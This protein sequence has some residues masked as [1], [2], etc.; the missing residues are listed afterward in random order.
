M[1]K[2]FIFGT[3]S[4]CYFLSVINIV[5]AENK[6]LKS[7][8]ATLSDSMIN[9]DKASKVN[10]IPEKELKSIYQVLTN[11]YKIKNTQAL[12]EGINECKQR[13]NKKELGFSNECIA[14]VVFQDVKKLTLIDYSANDNNSAKAMLEVIVEKTT[15][16]MTVHYSNTKELKFTFKPSVDTLK[17]DY[18]V[19][20][21]TY[22]QEVPIMKHFGPWAIYQG[23]NEV[24]VK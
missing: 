10:A 14:S 3:I 24:L 4:I 16:D 21:Y 1:I 5:K 9:P 7:S 17:A 8:A 22:K 13:K 19:K 6:N 23:E 15:Y 18:P 2:S 12:D 20:K 11:H